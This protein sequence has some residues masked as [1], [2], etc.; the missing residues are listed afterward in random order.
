MKIFDGYYLK[1]K[2]ENHVNVKNNYGEPIQKLEFKNTQKLEI[3]QIL[4]SII[5]KLGLM[6]FFQ[7]HPHLEKLI[8]NRYLLIKIPM[9]G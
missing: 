1:I 8:M 7:T 5:L 2:S 6:I 9:G 4:V 3:Y